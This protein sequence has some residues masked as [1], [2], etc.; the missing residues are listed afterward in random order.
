MA[1][2]V[3]G[4]TECMNVTSILQL[5]DI[6]QEMNRIYIN[7]LGVFGTKLQAEG[8]MKESGIMVN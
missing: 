3:I 6:K 8:K 5:E 2:I 4:V 1:K 7:I